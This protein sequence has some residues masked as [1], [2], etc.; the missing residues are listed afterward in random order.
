MFSPAGASSAE[1]SPIAGSRFPWLRRPCGVPLRE[2]CKH[3]HTLDT[4]RTF[5]ICQHKHARVHLPFRIADPLSLWCIIHACRH[6]SPFTSLATLELV[7]ER[8]KCL[9][10]I[11][12][13]TYV[14]EKT[15]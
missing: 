4:E 6:S 13:M 3:W 2:S 5:G 9:C 15:S 7:D 12:T 14:R 11:E 1:L 10:V 8:D